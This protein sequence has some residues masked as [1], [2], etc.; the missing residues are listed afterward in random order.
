[1]AARTRI[2][3]VLVA[4]T[5]T[6]GLAV[7]G[8][9]PAAAAP[10]V[11][12]S[13]IYYDSPGSDKGANTS[14]NGEYVTLKNSTTKTQTITGWTV[15]DAANHVYTFPTTKIAAGGTIKVHTG[16]GTNSGAHRYWGKSWY[17]WNNDKDT[18]TL[19]T[20]SG[21]TVDTCSYNSTRA[22]YKNC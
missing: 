15:R 3:A 8:A 2:G 22:D 11:S 21:S 18:A 9:G 13:K 19:R 17:V 6:L 7:M 4:S 1:M 10:A 5:V 16:K 12:I 20:G 14:L